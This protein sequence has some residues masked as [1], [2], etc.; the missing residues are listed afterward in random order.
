VVRVTFLTCDGV[1]KKADELVKAVEKL[2]L[3]QKK[4]KNDVMISAVFLF[5]GNMRLIYFVLIYRT[6]VKLLTNC[7]RKGVYYV[8]DQ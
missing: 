3:Q 7:I 2:G 5:Y 1:K 8:Q 4:L 6:G